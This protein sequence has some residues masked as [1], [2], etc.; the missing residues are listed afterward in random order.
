[1]K[2]FRV[3]NQYVDFRS[4]SGPMFN[5]VRENYGPTMR[6]GVLCVLSTFTYSIPEVHARVSYNL[7]SVFQVRHLH[8]I[9][10]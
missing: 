2:N 9:L 8:F 4:N 7:P 6:L 3:Y 5:G 1:M 10:Q